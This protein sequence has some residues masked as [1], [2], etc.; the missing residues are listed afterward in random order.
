MKYP[1]LEK[2]YNYLVDNDVSIPYNL[3]RDLLDLKTEAHY[4]R[5]MW[6]AVRDL[7]NKTLTQFEFEDVMIKV[8]E[9]QLRKAWYAGM[10]EVGLTP[11]DMTAE[12]EAE[13]QEIMLSEFDYV[14]GLAQSIRD[15]RDNDLP[16][17]PFKAR[18][19]LWVH[20]FTDVTNRAKLFCSKDGVRFKWVYGDTDHCTE[21]EQLNGL[22]ATAQEWQTSGI[23]PQSPPNPLLTCQGWNCGCSLEMTSQRR[24]PNAL[25]VLLNIGIAR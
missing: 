3:H 8:I 14:P 24:S 10:R 18:V 2:V 19:E 22:V 11:E 1:S 23:R 7:Y 6:R 20:R 5:V 16:I 25:D 21:C 17:D 15:A 9:S 4:T 12:Y 13:L